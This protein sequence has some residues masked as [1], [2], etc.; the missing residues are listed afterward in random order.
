MIQHFRPEFGYE[1][2]ARIKMKM[3]WIVEFDFDEAG[4][5][6]DMKEHVL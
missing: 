5:L 2:F 6:I 4:K 1:D 3:P